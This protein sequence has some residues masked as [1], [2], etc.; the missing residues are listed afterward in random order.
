MFLLE[1][2]TI[3]SLDGNH[4]KCYSVP[5][6]NNP[7]IEG[8]TIRM[9]VENPPPNGTLLTG[10]QEQYR[11]SLYIVNRKLHY[12]VL[13]NS[14]QIVAVSSTQNIETGV[15]QIIRNVSSVE[16]T[17]NNPNS[18][19]MIL[20]MQ[21]IFTETFGSV[22]FT[23]I[24][25][26]GGILNNRIY[27]GELQG[28]YYNLYYLSDARADFREMNVTKV[29]RV[30]FDDPRAQILLPGNL[31]D[32]SI[33][34]IELTFRTSQQNA[35]LL[36]SENSANDH[37]HI[38]TNKSQIYVNLQVDNQ[39]YSNICNLIISPNYWYTLTVEPVIGSEGGDH[40]MVSLL[41]YGSGSVHDQCNL[42]N[43]P[44][45]LISSFISSPVVVGGMAGGLDGLVG[46][47]ELTLNEEPLNLEVLLSD[48]IHADKCQP[49]DIPSPCPNGTSCQP[50]DD[51]TFT[52]NCAEPLCGKYH[53][54]N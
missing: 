27:S 3:I 4:Y 10:R 11:F 7:S 24:C 37:F 49:C 52:C 39:V 50:L 21:N 42:S 53:L 9:Y 14:I 22:R 51:R 30:N 40:F 48:N 5:R 47:L 1:P 46:C 17:I 19:R 35:T 34:R 16:I 29:N 43:L 41:Q 38:F 18:S 31:A 15:L 54:N 2:A 25:V 33:T 6:Y 23:E 32:G 12:E 45:G 8:E 13:Q 44:T 36:H 28:I 20:A 26:G